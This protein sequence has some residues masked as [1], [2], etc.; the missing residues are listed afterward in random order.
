M[1]IVT[2]KPFWKLRK[3]FKIYYHVNKANGEDLDSNHNREIVWSTTLNGT[4]SV[5]SK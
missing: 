3:N 1:Q 4:I 2:N 5:L